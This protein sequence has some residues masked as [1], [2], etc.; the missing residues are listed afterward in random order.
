MAKQNLVNNRPDKDRTEDSVMVYGASGVLSEIALDD[1]ELIIG[2][3]GNAPSA[4]TLASSGS[5]ITITDGAGT[6]DLADNS[7]SQA[8][9]D[10]GFLAYVGSTISN[11]TGDNT[12]YDIIYN[13][14]IYDIGSDYNTSDGVFTIPE[15]GTYFFSTGCKFSGLLSTH[16]G[17]QIT[18]SGANQGL[19]GTYCNPYNSGYS[20]SFYIRASGIVQA[21]AADTITT[22][23]AVFY[24][25]KV[26][27]IASY[28][29]TS[30]FNGFQ[31]LG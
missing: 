25:T 24:G 30:F 11:V 20:G 6:I 28:G 29:A 18:I 12:V 3:T 13:T 15:N 17:C 2:S 16:T 27:D 9:G 26:V 10:S 31:Y 4:S 19:W 1:G 8:L 22:K 5:T 14:E 7:P 23:L 21:D